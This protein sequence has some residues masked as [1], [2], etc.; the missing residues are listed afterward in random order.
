MPDRIHMQQQ[1]PNGGALCGGL[2]YVTNNAEETTCPECIEI[3]A[4]QT[5]T[6]LHVLHDPHETAQLHA[7]G[8]GTAPTMCGLYVPLE[9]IPFMGRVNCPGCLKLR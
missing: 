7:G 2:L 6:A 4:Q 1:Y 3:L 9:K 8:P 5:E